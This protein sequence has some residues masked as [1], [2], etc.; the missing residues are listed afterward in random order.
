MSP[1][2]LLYKH[3]CIPCTW[4]FSSAIELQVHI[5]KDHASITC[6]TCNGKK[7]DGLD[8]FK[9]HYPFKLHKFKCGR[10][11]TGLNGTDPHSLTKAMGHLKGCQSILDRHCVEVYTDKENYYKHCHT[12]KAHLKLSKAW[13]HED[14]LKRCK[15]R[16]E[17]EKENKQR[18][19]ENE[20]LW[21]AI[22]LQVAAERLEYERSQDYPA[23]EPEESAREDY[24]P[25]TGLQTQDSESDDGKF[26]DIGGFQIEFSSGED[27]EI[28]EYDTDWTDHA[29][30]SEE[31][32]MPIRERIKRKNK[33]VKRT[34]RNE[35]RKKEEER[36]KLEKKRLQAEAVEAARL[37][38]RMRLSK[39]ELEALERAER[40]EKER[41]KGV[42]EMIKAW[43]RANSVARREYHRM[44]ALGERRDD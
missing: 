32:R 37:E 34:N 41:M 42:E 2:N 44:K 14:Y 9:A 36:K 35:A 22:Q 5:I 40:K 23:F 7:F 10:C 16:E 20:N 19:V 17:R 38:A 31:E 43:V 11:G 6:I 33:N 25:A 12:D 28:S 39:Q 4:F 13:E 29:T 8:A 15:A 24:A 27:S 1:T 26:F 21:K 18:E 3:E 30:K